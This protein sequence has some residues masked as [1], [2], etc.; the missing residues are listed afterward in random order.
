MID[1]EILEGDCLNSLKTLPE[2]SVHCCVT[3]PPYFGL[4]SYIPDVVTP[5]KDTPEWV[6]EELNRLGIF[7]VDLTSK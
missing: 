2:K 5:K 6:F 7:P 3:S 4:R 1:Y